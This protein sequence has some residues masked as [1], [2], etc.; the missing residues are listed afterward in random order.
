MI[1]PKKC[2]NNYELLKNVALGKS[3]R[4]Q[5]LSVKWFHY[6]NPYLNPNLMSLKMYKISCQSTPTS[7]W[8]HTP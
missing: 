8:V 3:K 4:A 5:R 2:K 6:K 7:L 1:E